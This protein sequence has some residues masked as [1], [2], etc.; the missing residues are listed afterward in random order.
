M[1]KFKALNAKVLGVSVD[2][3]FT[4]LAWKKIPRTQGG[5]G[6]LNYPLFADISKDMSRD[7]GV[8]VEDKDDELYGAS[9]RGLFILNETGVIRHV[10]INDAPVGRNVDEVLRLIE[11]FQYTDTHDEVCPSNWKPG[12][13][14]IKPDQDDKMEFF[15]KEYQL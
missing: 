10:Q 2:S 3:H 14:T 1:P 11:A 12:S 15:S 7:Y 9:L 8:L 5:L 6:Q 13:R 4:H